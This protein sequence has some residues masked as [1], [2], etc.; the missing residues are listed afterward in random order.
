[1]STII[2]N[3]IKTPCPIMRS[4]GATR[5]K[6]FVS[7]LIEGGVLT[8]FGSLIGLLMGHGVL[9]LL[10]MMVEETQ[11]TGI[12]GFVFYPQEWVILGGSLM[13]GLACAILPAIQAYRVDISK[14]LSG[15]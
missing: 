2:D 4:M 3:N 10:S 5:S 6:L 9:I 12:S 7:I 8:L 15:N 1:S 13:L 14:V 11:K